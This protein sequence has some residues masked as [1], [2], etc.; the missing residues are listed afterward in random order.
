[1]S[2]TVTIVIGA[3]SNAE[4]GFARV[5]R[6]AS[7][8]GRSLH[9]NFGQAGRDSGLSFTDR[10]RNVMSQ[11]FASLGQSSSGIGQSLGQS[12][13]SAGSSPYVMAGIANMVATLAP[14][15]GTLLGGAIVLGVGGG[16]AAIGIMAASKAKV[17]QDAFGRAKDQIGKSLSEAAKP[18]EP[19]LVHVADSVSK[20]VKM[21]GPSLKTIFT[22]MAPVLQ[23]FF[24]TLMK[25]FTEAGPAL[26]PLFEAFNMLVDALGPVFQ[27]VIVEIAKALGD[28][29]KQ[30]Q[31]KDTIEAFTG[32]ISGLFA[33]LPAGIQ[34]ITWLSKEF[35]KMWPSIK[36]LGEAFMHLAEEAGPPLV[37]LL[38]FVIE[39][40]AE[41]WPH[42]A[43]VVDWVARFIGAIRDGAPDVIEKVKGIVEAIKGIK[44]SKTIKFLQNGAATVIEKAQAIIDWVRRIKN[45]TVKLAQ[46]GAS[47]V[48]GRV[49]D[50]I[51]RVRSIKNK[52]VKLAQSGA[53]TVVSNVQRCISRIRSFVGKSVHVGV[54]GVTSAINSVQNLINR[55]RN[56]TGKTVSVGVNFFKNAGGKLASALGFAHGG[57]VGAASGGARSAL[58]LVGEHGPEL[59][60]LAPGSRVHSNEDS[61]RMVSTGGG[62]ANVVLEVRSGGSRFD[63]ALTEIIRKVVWVKGGGDVQTAF[64]R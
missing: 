17:V 29:G 12:L 48:L 21:A 52:T 23:K 25:G 38:E 7:N 34:V 26:K 57:I 35:T 4:A 58:T 6:A 8:L 5:R 13:S 15:I 9:E 54:S 62:V 39:H 3:R 14:M 2:N 20:F 47:A 42:I 60:D 11:G 32:V 43:K 27:Q 10:L 63:D 33:I 45:K 30:F 18:L 64:G 41:M 55:I 59:V 51:D 56:L 40:M 50:V 16:L 53:S 31:N 37:K 28:L 24:D 22:D 36:K 49:Q 44:N 46:S 1:M 61:R 19:V